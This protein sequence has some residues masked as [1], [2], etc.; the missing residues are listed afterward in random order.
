[1]TNT[2]VGNAC[3]LH[4]TFNHFSKRGFNGYTW[5]GYTWREAAYTY[6]YKSLS[7]PGAE[8]SKSPSSWPRRRARDGGRAACRLLRLP[9]PAGWHPRPGSPC[10]PPTTHQPLASLRVD[11]MLSLQESKKREILCNHEDLRKQCPLNVETNMHGSP[12]KNYLM[13]YSSALR[14]STIRIQIVGA[15]ISV[16]RSFKQN[17]TFVYK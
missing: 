5:N 6:P 4:N 14:S 2:F 3:G 10:T 12:V 1:M 16:S 8:K 15:I 17:Y 9:G 7:R 13:I 11:E